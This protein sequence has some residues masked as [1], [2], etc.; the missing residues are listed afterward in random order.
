[1]M[2]W[3]SLSVT[4]GGEA[5]SVCT[6]GEPLVLTGAIVVRATAVIEWDSWENV[7]L[8]SA[9]SIGMAVE[10]GWESAKAMSPDED[11]VFEDLDT[12]PKALES[13]SVE[14]ISKL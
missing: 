8:S 5:V 9:D 11:D 12:V 10:L 7:R 6:L 14:I 4:F 3:D 1:M 13:P 2:R